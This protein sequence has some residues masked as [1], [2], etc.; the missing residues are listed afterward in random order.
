[1]DGNGKLDVVAGCLGSG[2]VHLYSQQID[3]SFVDVLVES[4]MGEI[5]A[6]D[7][8]DLRKTGLLDIVAADRTFGAIW[9]FKNLGDNIFETE[10]VGPP[11]LVGV[12]PSALTLEIGAW[13][14]V[15]TVP[16]SNF[17]DVT[18]GDFED[19]GDLEVCGHSLPVVG[20]TPALNLGGGCRLR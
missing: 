14:Q 11:G 5:F 16:N 2:E 7:V 12:C 3:G 20:E 10:E 18:V 19:D 8:G 13:A 6:V 15:A 17:R 1:M 4:G 9:Q